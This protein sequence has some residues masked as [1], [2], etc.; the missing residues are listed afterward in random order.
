MDISPDRAGLFDI[1]DADSSGAIEAQEL[2]HGLLQVR[3][4]ARPDP[5]NFQGDVACLPDARPKAFVSGFV[6]LKRVALSDCRF[7]WGAP[8][9]SNSP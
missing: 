6:S 5:V 4:D 7:A 3:G 2:I 1:L 9:G 8:Q